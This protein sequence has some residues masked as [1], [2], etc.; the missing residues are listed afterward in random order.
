MVIVALDGMRICANIK[1]RLHNLSDD[2]I[3]QF[4]SYEEMNS[5]PRSWLSVYELEI[6]YNEVKRLE[7]ERNAQE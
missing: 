3:K 4:L 6:D 7:F 5:L 2:Y 1:H